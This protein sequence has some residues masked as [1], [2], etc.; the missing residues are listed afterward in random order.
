ML[1]KNYI[2]APGPVTVPPEVLAAT[3]KPI[4][5]HRSAD[6]DPLFKNV[7]EGLQNAFQTKN[8]VCTFASSGTGAMEAAIVSTA[9]PG[10]KVI[11]LESGKFGERWGEI[12]QAFGFDANRVNIE[13]GTGPDANLLADLLKKNPETKAVY[14]TLCETS[15]GTISN[16]KALAEVTRNTDTLLIVDAVS[17]MAADELRSDEWGVD[18]VGTGGQ[19]GLMLPPGLGFLS[20]SE[21]AKKAVAASK[22]AKFYFSVAKALKELEKNTTPFTPAVSLLFGA[23]VALGMLQKEGMENVWKRHARLAEGARR[24]M[25][26]IGCEL[27]SKAPANTTTAVNVPAGVDGSKIVKTLRE[28]HGVTI[29]GGQGHLKGKIFRFATLGWYNEYDVATIVQ[30]VEATLVTLG[31]KCTRGAAVTAA[32]EYFATN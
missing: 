16:V 13:W 27:Y 10:D 7:Q 15:T 1:R 29:A 19:K 23:E 9:S 14:T 12:A 11:S 20:V 24:A 28:Q 3:A 17:G 22:S 31:H 5:H 18:M 25:K 32:A 6:F 2:F 21:K 4:I 8:P 30:A 26:A